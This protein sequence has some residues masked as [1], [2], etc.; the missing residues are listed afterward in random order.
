MN[1]TNI[2]INLI[3]LNSGQIEGL[4]KNP[5]FIK[6]DRFEAL[7]RSIEEAPEMLE[8]RSLLVYPHG[9]KYVTIGGNMRL[10]AC[11]EL[12]YKELPCVVLPA[13]TPAQKLK[14]Y[15]IKD[16]VAFGNISWDDL[17]NEW[18]VDE[19]ESWG[20]EC[21]FLHDDGGSWD[22]L[23]Y[24]NEE[25][26]KPELEK[27]LKIEILIPVDLKDK[28]E[29]IKEALKVTLEEFEGCEIK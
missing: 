23:D 7:K 13:D 2:K 17:A 8:Y 9:G 29:D 24:I 14:E 15:T 11:R 18:K 26:K 22:N 21:S 19:L 20:L 3:E 1:T 6:D 5:R 16:N 28:E 12:G 27:P 10:R 25:Q 4:P